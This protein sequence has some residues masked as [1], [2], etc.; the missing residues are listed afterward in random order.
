M[1]RVAKRER[2]PKK[3]RAFSQETGKDFSSRCIMVRNVIPVDY[4]IIFCM[5]NWLIIFFKYFEIQKNVS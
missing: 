4:V 5:G 2:K 1:A 3:I